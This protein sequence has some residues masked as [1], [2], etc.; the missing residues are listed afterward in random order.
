[1]TDA[2]CRPT[3]SSWRQDHAQLLRPKRS[4][5]CRLK[6][7]HHTMTICQGTCEEFFTFSAVYKHICWLSDSATTFC[8]I[9]GYG[10]G[11]YGDS[12]RAGR[13][14]DRIP[15]G[16][17]IFRTCPDRPCGPPSLLYNGY[18][19][20]PGGKAAGV[21]R[22]PPTPSNA[23]VKERVQLYLYSPS[24]SVWPVIGWTLVQKSKGVPRQAEMTQGVPGGL[25]PRI[26]L[27]FGHYKGGRS[28][29]KRTGRLYPRI[30][31][32]LPL[33]YLVMAPSTLVVVTSVLEEL[34]PPY[35]HPDGGSRRLMYCLSNIDYYYYYYLF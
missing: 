14:G 1:M 18:R 35:L 33:P 5:G 20:F 32:S 6:P 26:F 21:W 17:K 8:D 13:S 4:V 34:L 24:G 29:A 23:E 31:W 3:G 30:G 15:V 7:L 19:L 16:S 25:R 10:R 12:L 9:S 28:S 22:W 27:T 2:S 11:R